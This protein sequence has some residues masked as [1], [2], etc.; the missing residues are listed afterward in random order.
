MLDYVQLM[1]FSVFRVDVK[2]PISLVSKILPAILPYCCSK[3]TLPAGTK[4]QVCGRRN[5]PEGHRGP[6]TDIPGW[7]P[8]AGFGT[9]AQGSQRPASSFGGRSL[10]TPVLMSTV[11]NGGLVV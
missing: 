8:P 11:P 9:P 6:Y 10:T 3:L 7:V 2:L 5:C 4:A 1:N